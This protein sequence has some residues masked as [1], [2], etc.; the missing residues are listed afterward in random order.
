MRLMFTFGGTNYVFAESCLDTLAARRQ[1]SWF[2]C[3]T[4]GQL[5]AR[6]TQAGVL[7]ERATETMGRTRR[8]RFG[9]WP[10]RRAEQE[11]INVL[12]ASGLHYIG[13]WHTHPEK[14]P[15]PSNIDEDKILEIF[16]HSKHELSTMIILIVGQAKFPR[17]LYAGVVSAGK[18]TA[19]N[20]S[21]ISAFNSAT[22]SSPAR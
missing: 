9:F 4:G 6:F 16:R 7:V 11:D 2:S 10:D 17:G 5:F 14:H 3:E 12:F 18:L 20:L 21:L 8:T 15:L 22:S 19:T 1:R 13:D